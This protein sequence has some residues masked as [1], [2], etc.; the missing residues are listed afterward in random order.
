MSKALILHAPGTNRDGDLA[1]AIRLAGGEA[2][3]V[4][5]SRLQAEKTDWL[6]Y[7]LLALPGGFSY[8]DALG[9]GKLWALA[10]QTWFAHQ[11]QAFVESGR[12]I[13]GICNGFQALV[14][15]GF[16]P[17]DN[18]AATLAH[19]ESAQFECH[20]VTLTPN[21]AN[22]SFWLQRLESLV[23]PVAHGE[24]RFVTAH[25]ARLPDELVALRYRAADGRLADSRYPANPNGSP[26]DVAG[27]TNRDGNILGLMP[28]PENHILPYQHPNWTRGEQGGLGIQLFRNGLRAA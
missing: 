15:A 17:G 3:I 8:G 16:L 21:S 23:C 2:D 26:G 22:H 27:I 28:H 9:A 18:L 20:W 12:P 10:L 6:D 19:N 1:E 25:G 13:I 4:P 14:R 7:G 24:G 5:L 11:M